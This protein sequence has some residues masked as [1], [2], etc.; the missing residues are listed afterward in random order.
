[1]A[2]SKEALDWL[3]KNEAFPDLCQACMWYSE[4][5]NRCLQ[6]LGNGNSFYPDYAKVNEYTGEVGKCDGFE[7]SEYV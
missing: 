5:E 3:L 7:H 6:V 1:M 4:A 2:L